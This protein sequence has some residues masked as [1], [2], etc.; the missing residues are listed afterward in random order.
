MST[1]WENFT[2]F[3]ENYGP[4]IGAALIPAIITGLTISAKTAPAVG[5]V[6]KIWNTVK[7]VMNALSVLTHKNVDGTFQL[8]IVSVIKKDDAG[9]AAGLILIILLSSTQVSCAWFSGSKERAKAAFDCTKES[10]QHRASNLLPAMV[11]ILTG[12]TETWKDQA[13]EL[14]HKFGDD[15][16]GCAVKAALMKIEAP[17]QSESNIDPDELKKASLARGRALILEQGWKY[18]E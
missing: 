11:G 8:P 17:I 9:P 2:W 5:V 15:A 6:E 7:T 10:I 12:G 16:A 3:W 14:G 13:K 1:A 4:W 18:S